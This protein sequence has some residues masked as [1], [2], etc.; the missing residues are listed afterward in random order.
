[1]IY[2]TAKT[3]ASAWRN[4]I[5]EL[6]KSS[7]S[8]VPNL[9]KNTTAVVEIEDPK[10]DLYDNLFPMTR[11]QI[12]AINNH[13]VF[14]THKKEVIH[15]WT[16]LYRRRLVNESYNQIQNII[17]YLKKKPSGKRAQ[18][19]ILD[20]S[21]DLE[22]TIGPCLQII[23]CQIIDGKLELHAHMRA[24]DCYGKL[25]MNINEFAALQRYIAEQLGVE[26]G[27]YLQFIDSLH[28]NTEDQDKINSLMEKF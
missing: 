3:P 13:L 15:E 27:S 6:I 21:Q 8:K 14:G 18:M 22:A 16:L 5:K 25:L 26:C 17:D 2:V 4:S 19:S 11:E 9:W 24:C 23:F 12:E 28:F 7:D 1:M 20:P 10:A